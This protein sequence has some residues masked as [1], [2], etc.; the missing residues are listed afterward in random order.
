MQTP[1]PLEPEGAAPRAFLPSA[2]IHDSRLVEDAGVLDAYWAHKLGQALHYVKQY[3]VPK[4]ARPQ[5][6]RTK[7]SFSQSNSRRVRKVR[8]VLDKH[9]RRP[10]KVRQ[11]EVLVL[12]S[13]GATHKAPHDASVDAWSP[14]G[15]WL[16]LEQ[17]LRVQDGL[18]ITLKQ[19]KSVVTVRRMLC[20]ATPLLFYRQKDSCENRE[21]QGTLGK[22]LLLGL[23][24]AEMCAVHRP[25]SLRTPQGRPRPGLLGTLGER[26]EVRYEDV[27]TARR[28]AADTCSRG[29]VQLFEDRDLQCRGWSTVAPQGLGLPLAKHPELM[30]TVHLG[31]GSRS[32]HSGTFRSQGQKDEKL[33]RLCTRDQDDVYQPGRGSDQGGEDFR[34]HQL[35]RAGRSIGRHILQDD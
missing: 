26:D 22:A 4:P 24:Q 5:A 7:G 14:D 12:D 17:R 23:C 13:S 2:L 11:G 10:G 28:F 20:G 9:R 16:Y 30:S 18:K 21:A 33:Q 19:Q 34:S 6:A 3:R 32:R 1:G 15:R 25:S 35:F 8:Q 29:Q 31:R 27:V